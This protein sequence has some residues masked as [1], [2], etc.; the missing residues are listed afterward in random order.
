MRNGKHK[1]KRQYLALLLLVSLLFSSVEQSIKVFASEATDPQQIETS[2]EDIISKDEKSNK[3]DLVGNVDSGAG[4]ISDELADKKTDKTG[5]SKPSVP[6]LD[7]LEL[8]FKAK[9]MEI[10][11]GKTA[12]FDITIKVKD[13]QAKYAHVELL[14]NLPKNSNIVVDY[15]QIEDAT[16]DKSLMIGGVTPKYDE[17][18]STLTYIFSEL[19]S[20]DYKT[21]IEV[22]PQEEKTSLKG[23]VDSQK[24]LDGN[25]QLTARE[26]PGEKLEAKAKSKS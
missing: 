10:E 12:V 18:A 11:L 6:S 13:K 16:P 23:K 4:K 21:S 26:F 7:N 9:D 3:K 24:S 20:G 8:F 2:S 14:V 17:K 25:I 5:E 19:E 1:K 15:P 22:I